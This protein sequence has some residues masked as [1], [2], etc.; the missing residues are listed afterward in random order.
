MEA[1]TAPPA[2]LLK[3]EGRSAV[4][5]AAGERVVQLLGGVA[6]RDYGDIVAPRGRE[7]EAWEAVLGYWDAQPD[8]DVLDLHA[9]R[10]A[11][12]A[13]AAQAAAALGWAVAQGI[14][15]TCPAL[16]LP[17]TW[18]DYVA[19]LGKKDRHELRRKLRRIEAQP[20]AIRQ[21]VR[22]HG[23][24]VEAALE[25]FLT[26]HRL[27][28]AAKAAFMT[29]AMAGFFR[30]L[31]AATPDGLEIAT[32]Y[33]D[34]QPAAAYLSFCVG[35]RLLLYNSGYDPQ[36]AELGAG[37]AL[38]VYRIEAAIHAGLRVFDFLRGDERY[39]YD[40]GARD[41]FVYRVLGRRTAA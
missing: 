35:D 8:W 2:L 1:T 38:L 10:P 30:N 41:H 6:V 28:G 29:P 3:G 9:L 7:A 13:Q 27:S 17:A 23:P 14:E 36:Y 21:A 25:E 18:D 15:E 11:V 31:V 33:V 4:V 32:L 24:D 5:A 19:G 16:D 37:F 12:A 34:E 20:A 26:L 22:T 39:K 40:L